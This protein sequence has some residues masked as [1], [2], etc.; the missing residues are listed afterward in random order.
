LKFLKFFWI[1]AFMWMSCD[2]T[3]PIQ[4]PPDSAPRVVELAE[5]EEEL[6]GASR[7]PD[8]LLALNLNWEPSPAPTMEEARERLSNDPELE[9][10][11]DALSAAGWTDEEAAEMVYWSGAHSSGQPHDSV[12]ARHHKLQVEFEKSVDEFMEEIEQ[13]ERINNV[14]IDRDAMFE[15]GLPTRKKEDIFQ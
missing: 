10:L 11:K 15:A 7:T 12:K 3:P 9:A 2:S 5:I 14:R 13:Y 1:L 4:E 6:R 8:E